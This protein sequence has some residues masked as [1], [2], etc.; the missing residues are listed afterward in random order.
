MTRTLVLIGHGMVGKRLIEALRA[1]EHG[2]DWRVVALAEEARPA[3]DRTLLSS[4]LTGGDAERSAL[5]TPSVPDDPAVRLMLGTPAVRVKPGR[6]VVHAAGG[7]RVGYDALVFATGARPFVPPVPGH[8]RPGCFAYRTL[9]DAERVR[10][11]A[12]PGRPAVVVG[13]GVL[14]LEAAAALRALGM[15]VHLVERSDRLMA[16]Q[17]DAAAARVLAAFVAGLGVRVHH[18]TTV[19]SVDGGPGGAVRGVTFAGGATLPAG[20]IVF[21]AGVRPRDELAT[22]AGLTVA[23]RGGIA[24][25]DRCRTADPHIW[26]IGDCAAVHGRCYGLVNPGYRMAEVVAAQ[27]L[28][29][30][31]KTFTGSDASVRLKVMGADV[32]SF[33]DAH[34]RTP[35]AVE[36]AQLDRAAG[37]YAKLVLAA[38]GRT[39][40]GGILA[41][42]ARA[43]PT[44]RAMLGRELTIM[45]PGL[46]AGAASGR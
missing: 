25:D 9:D 41:G 10:R 45:P 1:G 19:A 6:R 11:A 40:L 14:G 39:L 26:A 42:D 20:L 3:Y 30:G 46:L 44:L 35:G 32:A 36:F 29:R 17:L 12:R 43:Y 2:N 8:D 31:G 13:G 24:V 33:G 18:A 7:E 22:A 4:Y 27:L 34:A 37:R 15:R 38:D 23:P 5:L 21:A 16:A 28:G